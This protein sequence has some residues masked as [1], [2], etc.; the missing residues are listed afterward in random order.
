MCKTF[1]TVKVILLATFTE[2]SLSTD[3]LTKLEN[4]QRDLLLEGGRDRVA[5]ALRSTDC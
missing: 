4:V 2:P 1:E 3:V 5:G